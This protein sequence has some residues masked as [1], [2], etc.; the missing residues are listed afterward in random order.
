MHLVAKLHHAI[1][2]GFRR[3]E[4]EFFYN[5]NAGLFVCPE[6]H[7]ALKNAKTGRTM[8]RYNPQETHYFDIKYCQIC[9]SKVGCYKEEARL[10]HILLSLKVIN[11]YFRRDFRKHHII[12][13]RIDIAIT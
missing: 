5:K 4:D 13:K 7:M 1:S 6:G 2:R 9:P 12:K 3:K 8:E 11:T 10:K